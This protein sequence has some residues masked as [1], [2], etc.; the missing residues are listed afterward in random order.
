MSTNELLSELY[1]VLTSSLEMLFGWRIDA[2]PQDAA[3]VGWKMAYRLS[4]LAGGHWIWSGSHLVTDA[5]V[6]RLKIESA[7]HT[8]WADSS[9]FFGNVRSLELDSEWQ[10]TPNVIADFVAL[11]L[12]AD[13]EW[14]IRSYLSRYQRIIKNAKVERDHAIQGWSVRDIPAISLSISSHIISDW[15]LRDY[16]KS[17]ANPDGIKGLMVKDSTSSYKG[18][19]TQIVGS[20]A[21]HRGRL[22]G[23]SKRDKMKQLLR[24]APDDDLVVRVQAGYNEGYDYIASTLQI[25][26]RTKDYERLYI[27]G[28]EALSALQIKPE[29]RLAIVRDIAKLVQSRNWI[30]RYPFSS[31]SAPTH[32]LN[33]ADIGFSPKARLGDGYVCACDPKSVLGAL[34]SHPPYKRASE[35]AGS[36]PIRIGIL[37]LIGDDQSI[38][39]YLNL[40]RQR[41]YDVKY[42]VKFTTAQRPA[43]GSQSKLEQA[44][45]DLILSKP[46]IVMV[47]LPGVANREEEDSLYNRIK[48]ASVQRDLPS[49]VIYGNTLQ[50]QYAVDN[51]VLGILAKIG[52][53]PYVL[54]ER[55]QYADLIAGI[56][57][58]R[59]RAKRRSGSVNIAA[60]TRIYSSEGDFIRYILDDTPI[61]GETLNAVTIRKLFPAD[62]F[63]GRK[64]IIHRDGLFRGDESKHFKQWGD[65]IGTQF[66]LVEV[67]K[68]GAPRLFYRQNGKIS[69]PQKGDSFVLN[70]LEAILVSSLPAHKNS[71][72][73]PLV[74]RTDGS[75]R[76][77][78]ALHS[79]LSMTML[80]FGS[81]RS[82]R[83]PVTIHYSDRIGYLALRGIKPKSRIGIK[84]YWV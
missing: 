51:I 64:A 83:L 29:D 82:P 52:N 55:I 79:V 17:L 58:A 32:F 68:S 9:A 69:S 2:N 44:I 19:I 24:D 48:A 13:L 47:L 76:I 66:H 7:L 3:L 30:D 33:S 80:H 84:P 53:I 38:P 40:I 27:N 41:L 50:N 59:E 8:I 14:N 43:N 25:V 12:C 56:D 67:I 81:L 10:P 72:P 20:L 21:Q 22:I 77:E 36:L 42:S 35:I 71:T 78:E 5:N 15:T 16:V 75:L 11:G 4:R 39:A 31:T 54:A 49:Q 65:E 57:I 34:G 37:N 61:E 26:V 6:T 46:H 45:G 28:Q 73:K 62:H 1:P 18:E 60:M 70:D 63:A 74:I 23:I